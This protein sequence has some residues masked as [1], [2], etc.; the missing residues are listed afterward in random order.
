[1]LFL[2]SGSH[3][4]I[5]VKSTIETIP[6]I[7]T[8]GKDWHSHIGQCHDNDMLLPKHP[9]C[10]KVFH[11]RQQYTS[12]SKAWPSARST[13]FS[14]TALAPP[15]ASVPYSPSTQLMTC[16]GKYQNIHCRPQKGLH[17]TIIEVL[18]FWLAPTGR[19][20]KV[21][22]VVCTHHFAIEKGE[23]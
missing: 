22:H 14:V 12:S 20:T 3:V 5:R 6:A 21:S 11:R 19:L 2:Q 15:G 18:S 4:S 17:R 16:R 1:M 13:S 8:R 7:C 9:I 10:G 23:L